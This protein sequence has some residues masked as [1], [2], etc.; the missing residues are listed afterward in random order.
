MKKIA[1]IS[2]L[3]LLAVATSCNQEEVYDGNSSTRLGNDGVLEV[4]VTNT[5]HIPSTVSFVRATMSRS[6]LGEL[7]DSDEFCLDEWV[8]ELIRDGKFVGGPLN[9]FEE[10]TVGEAPFNSGFTM[11]L[12]NDIPEAFLRSVTELEFLGDLTI[13]NRDARI[14]WWG[15]PEFT[16]YCVAGEWIGSF[17]SSPMEFVFSDRDVTISGHQPCF[18]VHQNYN[19]SLTRGWNIIYVTET[20]H[21]LALSTRNRSTQRPPGSNFI[22]TMPAFWSPD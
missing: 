21:S 5:L 11:Q 7:L 19:L 2:L 10:I 22:W 3:M 20:H 1:F 18:I 15:D 14:S 13:S 9:K 12:R 17:S 4:N 6:I 8:D 16:G